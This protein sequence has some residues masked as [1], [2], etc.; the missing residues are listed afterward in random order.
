[1]SFFF[2]HRKVALEETMLSPLPLPH[3]I[4]HLPSLC[5]LLPGLLCSLVCVRLMID[6]FRFLL[7]DRLP[8]RLAARLLCNPVSD[9][10]VM[11]GE[12]DEKH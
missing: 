2:P 10:E 1:M 11:V 6:L 12:E 9:S 8:T 4:S 5:L 3:F 7:T